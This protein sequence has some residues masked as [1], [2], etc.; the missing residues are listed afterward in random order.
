MSHE[1]RRPD[2]VRVPVTTDTMI[3]AAGAGVCSLEH[4]GGSALRRVPAPDHSGVDIVHAQGG[5]VARYRRVMKALVK[6]KSQPGL[7]LADVAPP[8]IGINDVLI[9]GLRTGIDRKSTRLNSSHSLHDALP[10]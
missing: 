10:I 6:S 9:R 8:E 4:N 1:T 5:L 2:E 3:E 7:W